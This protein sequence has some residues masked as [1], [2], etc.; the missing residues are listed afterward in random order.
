MTLK[1]KINLKAVNLLQEVKDEIKNEIQLSDYSVIKTKPLIIPSSGI[2]D[3]GVTIKG[4]VITAQLV[5]I[6]AE[7][8]D[9]NGNIKPGVVLVVEDVVPIAVRGRE[10]T[11]AEAVNKYVILTF[12][13]G[14]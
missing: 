5:D 12:L 6:T 10:V 4:D 13:A 11:I 7:N 3:V 14:D 8:I 9:A 2:V 1:I